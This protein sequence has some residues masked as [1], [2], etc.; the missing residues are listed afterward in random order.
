VS[1]RLGNPA[2]AAY[3]GVSP[4]TWRAYVARGQAPKPDG[5]DEGFGRDYWLKSTLDA[6]NDSRPGPGRPR[7]ESLEG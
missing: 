6:W 4:S 5:R 7:K 2:A 1:D 3:V